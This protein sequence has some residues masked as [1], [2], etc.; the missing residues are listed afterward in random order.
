[1]SDSIEEAIHH[2]LAL[3]QA[4]QLSDAQVSYEAILKEHPDHPEALHLI[5]LVLHQQGDHARAA[6]VLRRAA[7]LQPGNS[8]YHYNAGVVLQKL[9]QDPE[10]EAAY[11]RALALDG[12]MVSAWVNLGN[13]LVDHGHF[14]EARDCHR[15]A[16]RLNLN[17]AEHHERLARTLRLIGDAEGA[18]SHLGVAIALDPADEKSQSSLLF[19]SQYEAGLER[20]ELTRRHL[21]WGAR[22]TSATP[23]PHAPAKSASDEAPLTVGFLSADLGNHPVGIFIAPLLERLQKRSDI[24]TICYNDADKDDEFIRRN[25]RTSGAWRDTSGLDDDK[26]AGMIREDEVEILFEL[27]GH[28]EQNRLPLIARR[29]APV[30]V[31]WAGY[32]G[33]TGLEAIDYLLTD[34]WQSPDGSEDHYTETLLRF[35]CDYI[36]YEAPL[37]SPDPG[38]LPMLDSGQVTFGCQNNP[39]KINSFTVRVWSRILRALPQSGLILKYK[40]M[41]D[42]VVRHRILGLFSANGVSPDRIEVIGQT[43]HVEHLRTFRR[44]DIALDPMP[45]SGGLSTCEALWMGV[46]VVTCPGETFASR[47]SLSHLNNAGV[48]DTI[49]TDWDDYVRIAV[50]LASDPKALAKRRDGL[51]SQ[52]QQSPLCDL[53]A[54]ADDFVRALQAISPRA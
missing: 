52:L 53:D 37:Y 16:L 31:T 10:A 36:C 50:K 25:R 4:G 39:S 29:P 3:H 54:Y 1:M 14:G 20:S 46:P 8:A 22:H 35:P 48:T 21:A 32:V 40:G 17:S 15:N 2:A 19:A 51:R 24:R 42:P 27:A 23:L 44:I 34:A 33:T 45:Y 26:V 28:T 43:S 9:G 12:A 30:Q 38:P 5:G 41:D 11:R 7:E 18:V 13:L 47:H 6:E 49:A